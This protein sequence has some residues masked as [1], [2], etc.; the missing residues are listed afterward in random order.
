[1]QLFFSPTS[2]YVRKVRVTAMD[3]GLGERVT[4]V[5]CNPHDPGPELL[6]ANPL[7][8]VP[9]LLRERGDALFDSPVICAWLD[10]AGE[11]PALIP[12]DAEARWA[13]LRGEAMADGILDDAV[14]LVMERR[15]SSGEQNPA[16]QAMRLAAIRRALAW[17]DTE[18]DWVTGP[19]NLAQIAVGCALGYLDFRL[20]ELG[21]G[22]DHPALAAWY[23]DFA[24]R[25]AMQATVPRDPKA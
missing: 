1:M 2:P 24:Q 15:R 4:L 12:D 10:Q 8:R 17:L 22:D 5:P 6:A 18:T 13:V 20:P 25:P 21:W 19:L 7:G 16:I 3:K 14:G 9:T 23:Q 11:G